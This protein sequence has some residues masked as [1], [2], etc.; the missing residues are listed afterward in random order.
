M[1]AVVLS[2]AG[3]ITLSVIY[4]KKNTQTTNITHI[5]KSQ[6]QKNQEENK[7]T[8]QTKVKENNTNPIMNLSSENIFP[9]VNFSDY[10]SKIKIINSEPI[11]DENMI[12]YIIQDIIKKLSVNYGK[13]DVGYFQPKKNQLQLKFVWKSENQIIYKNYFFN[14]YDENL[15]K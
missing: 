12:A 13:I 4:I 9:S 10:Y 7:K 11:I 1:V 8:Q 15:K 3:I 6:K 14:L 2:L 5:N